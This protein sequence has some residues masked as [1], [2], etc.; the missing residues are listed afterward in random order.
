MVETYKAKTLKIG[1]SLYVIIPKNNRV[2]GQIAEGDVVTV[3]LGKDLNIPNQDRATEKA[4]RL[5]LVRAESWA[6]QGFLGFPAWDLEKGT[7]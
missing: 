6:A 7:P 1:N 2:F 3:S 4:S 5:S